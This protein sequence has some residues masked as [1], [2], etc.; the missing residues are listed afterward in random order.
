MPEGLGDPRPLPRLHVVTND[1]MLRRVG[2]ESLAIEVLEAGGPRVAVHVRGP[3][4]EGGE[5]YR[6]VERL[7][8]YAR[9]TGGN[10][11]VN[12]RVDVGLVLD[13]DGVHLGRRS[14]PVRMARE[15]LD[16]RAV[17]IGAS[18]GGGDGAA[19]LGEEGA[20]YVFL[21]TIFE[22]PT[23]PGS[24]GMGLAD[25]TGAVESARDVPVIGIGGIDPEKAGE[26]RRAGAW[27]AAVVRGVWE[28]PDAAAAVR[29]Y[30][31]EMEN[32]RDA[33]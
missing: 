2:W 8:P 3:G 7:L 11:F 19:V 29:R 23:H 18:T 32:G 15:L 21:G 24:S 16:G 5:I 28:A 33:A 12:D 1:A 22:T 14:L 30:L 20:D 6:H 27:G 10:L 31:D 17:W 4:T 13:V 26:V 9:R 25:L